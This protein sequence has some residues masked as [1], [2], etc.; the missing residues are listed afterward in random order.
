M[1]VNESTPKKERTSKKYEILGF[2]LLVTGIAV[3][4]GGAF[5]WH[6]ELTI[7]TIAVEGNRIVPAQEIMM[8]ANI[9]K[10]TR[11]S[12]VEL[13]AIRNRVLQNPFIKDAIV[14]RDLPDQITVSVSE[15]TPVAFIGSGELLSCDAEGIVLP[16]VT[17]NEVTNLPLIS[18]VVDAAELQPGKSIPDSGL[19]Q[20]L[21]LILSAAT[22]DSSVYQLISEVRPVNNREMIMYTTD[23]GVPVMIGRGKIAEKIAILSSFWNEIIRHETVQRLESVDVR[24]QDQVVV[25]WAGNARTSVKPG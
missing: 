1:D 18:G 7:D 8:L 21:E 2:L 23:G 17:S 9:Q 5:N 24:F 6:S 3:I 12:A 10:D 14:R 25:R 4:A 16:H 13:T 22:I 19:R 15:R 20:A 11:I